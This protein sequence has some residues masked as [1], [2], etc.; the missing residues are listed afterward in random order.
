MW[1]L[2]QSKCP[3]LLSGQALKQF[4]AFWLHEWPNSKTSNLQLF[5]YLGT[6]YTILSSYFTS[7]FYSHGRKQNNE[8]KGYWRFKYNKIQLSSLLLTVVIIVSQGNTSIFCNRLHQMFPP[9]VVKCL[10][11]SNII[12]VAFTPPQ[13]QQLNLEDCNNTSISKY[14]SSQYHVL[15]K[16]LIKYSIE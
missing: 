10:G 8:D 14:S 16:K 7:L 3:K 2:V 15:I 1:S 6:K 5:L 4:R 9:D 11:K 13:K 12:E